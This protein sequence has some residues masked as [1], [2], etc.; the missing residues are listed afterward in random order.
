APAISGTPRDGATLT[1]DK[2]TWTGTTPIDYAYQWRRCGPD[3][4]GCADIPG[5]TRSTYVAT[6]ADVSGTLRVAVAATNVAGTARAT[7]TSTASVDGIAPHASTAPA[8]SGTP[9]DGA[10]LAVEP[11]IWNGSQPIAFA[12]QWRRC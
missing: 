4:S 11:G 8:V 12:Y 7:S 6:S 10:T 5:A 3:G 9:A 1:A 2:G